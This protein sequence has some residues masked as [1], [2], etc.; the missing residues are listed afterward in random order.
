MILTFDPV[1]ALIAG[2]VYGLVAGTV[3]ILWV[4]YLIIKGKIKNRR[5]N[6]H[7]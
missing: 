3:F 2:I 7:K 6:R 1:G 4:F 5:N